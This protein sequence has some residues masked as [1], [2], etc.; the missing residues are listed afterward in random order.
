MD[1]NLL[2]KK[3]IRNVPHKQQQNLWLFHVNGKMVKK[4]TKDYSEDGWLKTNPLH[5]GIF[6]VSS[7]RV[8]ITPSD[9]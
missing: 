5:H 2:E 6:Y 9:P 1:C 3:N 7:P 4:C 8:I